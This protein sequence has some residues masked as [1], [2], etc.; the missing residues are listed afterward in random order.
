MTAIL[1]EGN[2]I[3][4]GAWAPQ[5]G[6]DDYREFDLFCVD[7]VVAESVSLAKGYIFRFTA[8]GPPRQ[9]IYAHYDIGHECV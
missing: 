4:F 9:G 5:H 1:R 7:F 6:G 8:S 3:G 2:E